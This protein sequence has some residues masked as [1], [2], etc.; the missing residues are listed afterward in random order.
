MPNPVGSTE[1]AIPM[2]LTVIAVIAGS[3][4]ENEEYFIVHGSLSDRTLTVP[5]EHLATLASAMLPTVSSAV[6]A[7]VEALKDP[8]SVT[9]HLTVSSDTVISIGA[10]AAA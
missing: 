2:M 5:P 4:P 10:H 7:Y 9:L 3:V 1:N 6:L 8:S